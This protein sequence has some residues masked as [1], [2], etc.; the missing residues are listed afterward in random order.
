MMKA[1]D[2]IDS[3]RGPYGFLSNFFPAY[4]ML[5]YQDFPTVE[6]A[7]QAAKTFDIRERVTILE[8]DTPGKA[9]QLGRRVTLR[10]DWEDVKVFVMEELV[11]RKFAEKN[12]RGKLLRTHPAHLEEGNDWGD[13]F[14]GTVNGEGRNE[15]GQVLMRVRAHI[16]KRHKLKF[17]I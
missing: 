15:L 14:W 10:P 12:L 3:F 8:A 2:R 11:R 9:K 4:V 6:H 7:F 13:R 16:L 1:T 17:G 5:D